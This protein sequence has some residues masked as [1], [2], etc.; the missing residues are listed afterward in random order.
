MCR[1]SPDGNGYF[2]GLHSWQTVIFAGSAYTHTSLFSMG[3]PPPHLF[4]EVRVD[5]RF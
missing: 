4:H 1:G 5:L 2:M 3:S